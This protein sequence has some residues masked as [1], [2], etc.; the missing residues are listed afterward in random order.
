[1]DYAPLPDWLLIGGALVIAL[2]VITRDAK[3]RRWLG[4]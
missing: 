4:L 2:Y 1:M 3:V